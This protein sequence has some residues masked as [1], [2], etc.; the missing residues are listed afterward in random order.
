MRVLADNRKTQVCEEPGMGWGVMATDFIPKGE[1]ICESPFVLFPRSFSLGESVYKLLEQ[2]GF[3][4][5]R[6]KYLQNLVSNL[7]FLHPN[8]YFFKWMPEIQLNGEQNVFCVIPTGPSVLFNSSNSQNNIGWTIKDNELFVF[9]AEKDIQAGEF[10]RSFF[11]YNL[12][13]N[14]EIFPCLHVFGL[15][16]DHFEN[17]KVRCKAIR[18]GTVEEYENSKTN[19]AQQRCLQIFQ[20]SKDGGFGISKITAM[21]AD[22]GEKA[23]IDLNENMPLTF[24]YTKITEFRN[25]QFPLIKFTVNWENKEGIAQSEGIIFRK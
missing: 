1:I 4:S 14:G 9:R 6:E 10:L 12:G 21:S 19:P 22:G 16:L 23:A 18:F 2:T 3:L 13:E 24:I 5:D 15:G 20:Q 17:E 11:G 25:S 8:A 7:K